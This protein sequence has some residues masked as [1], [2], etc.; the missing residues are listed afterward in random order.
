M[1][2]SERDICQAAQISRP[3]MANEEVVA[4]TRSVRAK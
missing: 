1:N 3:L 2:I 4:L